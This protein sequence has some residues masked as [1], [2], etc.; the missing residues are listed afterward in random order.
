MRRR[1][2]EDLV[3]LSQ[4]WGE[5]SDPGRTVEDIAGDRAR[6]ERMLELLPAEA[7]RSAVERSLRAQYEKELA[8][9][10]G[11]PAAIA[12]VMAE[13]DPDLVLPSEDELRA[14]LGA[15]F[16]LPEAL[17][18]EELETARQELVRQLAN[19]YLIAAEEWE[20]PGGEGRVQLDEGL[21]PKRG[22]TAEHAR[23]H[24]HWEEARREAIE[25]L[26]SRIA[27]S[28]VELEALLAETYGRMRAMLAHAPLELPDGWELADEEDGPVL[29]SRHR[30]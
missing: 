28:R 22:G 16:T 10:L 21:E 2:A 1:F 29:R 30:T 13:A 5:L 4:P 19:L 26:S 12:R 3:P 27:V 15:G 20:G 6:L 7:L 14:E 17:F 18:S 24:A 11:D 9:A 23:A 8:S 25:D